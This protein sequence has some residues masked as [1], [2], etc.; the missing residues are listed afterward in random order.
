[1]TEASTMIS[2]TMEVMKNQYDVDIRWT[3]HEVPAK[4]NGGV[5]K[6]IFTVQGFIKT[7]I[8]GLHYDTMLL[9]TADKRKD[10]MTVRGTLRITFD[11]QK[12]YDMVY[13]HEKDKWSEPT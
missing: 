12:E 1:M 5:R 8:N 9:V 11:D 10:P 7:P 3:G 13:S 2:Y 4:E 6:E